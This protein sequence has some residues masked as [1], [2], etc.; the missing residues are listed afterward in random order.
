VGEAFPKR[1]KF[2]LTTG[3]HGVTLFNDV[4]IKAEII[5]TP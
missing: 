3:L 4:K 2:F 5:I 1:Y